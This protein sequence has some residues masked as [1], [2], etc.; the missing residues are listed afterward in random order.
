[1]YIKKHDSGNEYIY[2]GDVWV[3]NFTKKKVAPLQI[4]SLFSQNDFRNVIENQQLNLNF[5]KISDETLQF[6]KV[7]I[8]SDGFKFEEK[9]SLLSD[10]PKDVCILATNGALNKWKLFKKD[11][12]DDKKR[13]INAYV[14]NNPFK[15]CFNYLPP[16]NSKYYPVC[17]A[18][19]RANHEFLKKYLGDVYTYCP[20][21]E[22]GF[23]IHAAEQY[24][25]DDYRNPICACISL[26]YQFGVKKLMLF[27]CD[28]S[29]EK[30]RE[31]AIQL[32][33]KLWTYSSLLRSQ[34]IID[35]NLYWLKNQE[36]EE[37]QI[38]DHSS[39]ADYKCATYIK[40]ED[41]SSFF[42]D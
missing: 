27:C 18:S 10:L 42:N 15:E 21:F 4:T 12:D 9:Q 20:T 14:V 32:P 17:I 39:G 34:D 35:A 2:A 25:V 28:D 22:S 5:P 29:F 38:V 37:I 8:V 11:I 16:Q 31:Q 26:A 33:N 3:R 19:L 1:M 41:I 36:N 40:G 7:V 24:F 23:G 30:S 13:S 6:D